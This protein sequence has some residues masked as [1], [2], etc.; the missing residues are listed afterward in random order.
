MQADLILGLQVD[1]AREQMEGALALWI[2]KLR[3]ASIQQVDRNELMNHF[4][5]LARTRE[6]FLW[7]QNR[8]VA[9]VLRL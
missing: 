6:K 1:R 4:V 8:Y 7:L 3:S 9:R 5:E 2:E